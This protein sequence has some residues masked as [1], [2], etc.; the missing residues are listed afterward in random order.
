NE[1]NF[2]GN[3]TKK[4]V[5]K[6]QVKYSIAGPGDSGYGFV[7]PKTRAK[8]NEVR[9]LPEQVAPVATDASA[10]TSSDAAAQAQLDLLQKQVA[11][12]L[13]QLNAAQ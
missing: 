3:L 4:A 6:F 7:G 13:E 8:L 2:F 12:L 10:Q 11:E 9:G 1:T 5:E